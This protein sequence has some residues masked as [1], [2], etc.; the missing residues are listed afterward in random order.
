MQERFKLVAVE[1]RDS[2]YLWIQVGIF[3]NGIGE[4]GHSQSDIMIK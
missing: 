3:E 2:G 1:E 4:V